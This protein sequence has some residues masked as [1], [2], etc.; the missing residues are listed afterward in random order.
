LLPV[1]LRHADRCQ[2]IVICGRNKE[3]YNDLIHWRANHPEFNCYVEGYSD[4]VHLL[5]QVS[6][7]I[8]TRGGTTTCT[9]A[10]HLQCPL[11]F[12]AFGGIMPQEQLTWKFFRNGGFVAEDRAGRRVRRD[13]RGVARQS[14]LLRAGARQFRRPAVR[15]GSDDSDRRSGIPR[16]RG[17]ADQTPPPLLP[18]KREWSAEGEWNAGPQVTTKTSGL[19]Y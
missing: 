9:E 7:V 5:M 6:D 13:H 15:G 12:N 11:I 1:L 4:I 2:A 8:V 10:L 16:K 18:A 17:R 19:Q 3:T 14:G